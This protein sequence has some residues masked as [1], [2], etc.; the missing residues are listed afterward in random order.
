MID[1][2]L[3]DLWEGWSCHCLTQGRQLS[4]EEKEDDETVALG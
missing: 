1:L 2:R 4:S 3:S